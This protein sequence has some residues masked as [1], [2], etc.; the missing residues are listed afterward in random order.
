MRNQLKQNIEMFKQVQ[1]NTEYK[2]PKE[3]RIEAE[4]KDAIMQK[5]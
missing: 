4:E 3:K 5:L 2:T 1:Y